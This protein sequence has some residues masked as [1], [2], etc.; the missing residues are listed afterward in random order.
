MSILPWQDSITLLTEAHTATELRVMI[1]PKWQDK[2]R[3]SVNMICVWGPGLFTQLPKP[4]QASKLDL[5]YE[6]EATANI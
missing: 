5:V 6:K 3:N 1:D 4:T 2:R